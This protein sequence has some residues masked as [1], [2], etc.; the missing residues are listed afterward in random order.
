MKILIYDRNEQITSFIPYIICLIPFFDT[1][2][3][4]RR[5]GFLVFTPEV[6]G[7]LSSLFTPV[8]G[9]GRGGGLKCRGS[10]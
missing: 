1:G 8:V 7:W 2:D 10:E 3:W 9:L 6:D 5:G 4:V